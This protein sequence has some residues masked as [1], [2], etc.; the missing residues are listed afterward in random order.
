MG[1]RAAFQCHVLSPPFN[2]KDLN[3]IDGSAF[4]E[5][6]GTLDLQLLNVCLNEEDGCCVLLV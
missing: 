5:A 6:K 2:R 3:T 1:L 4:H